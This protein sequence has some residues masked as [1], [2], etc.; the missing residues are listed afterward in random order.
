[1][2]EFRDAVDRG[3]VLDVGH[4]GTDF[5]FRE[6]RRLFDQGYRPD[7]I[8]T[9][10]NIFNIGGPVFSLAENMTKMFALGIDTADVI[11][12]AT[13]NP[14]RAIGRLD[15]LGTLAVGRSAEISV[16]RLRSDGPFPVSDGHETLESDIAVEPVGCVRAGSWYPTPPL[17][18]FAQTGTTWG[19]MPDDEDW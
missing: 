15:E 16:L 8:S 2:P 13:R 12:M 6:A 11:A 4:S 1:M 5:R 10:L 18:T 3:V 9:D 17:P 14:A 19:D 7:T